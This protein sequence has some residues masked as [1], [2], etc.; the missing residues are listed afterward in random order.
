MSG[1]LHLTEE[2]SSPPESQI[3]EESWTLHAYQFWNLH[4]AAMGNSSAIAFNESGD[5][6]LL[7]NLTARFHKPLLWDGGMVNL[8]VVY[9]NETVFSFETNNESEE[10]QVLILIEDCSSD[11][12][13]RVL[14]AGSD[15]ATD[16]KPGDYYIVRVHSVV[17]R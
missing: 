14:A 4:P 12:Y 10:Y 11:I 13:I 6:N 9:E 3:I 17:S 8:S 1:Y 5:V 7:I 15:N 16:D 2:I